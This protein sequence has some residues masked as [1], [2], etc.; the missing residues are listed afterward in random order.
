MGGDTCILETNGR[1]K[2]TKRARKTRKK[3]SVVDGKLTDEKNL[4]DE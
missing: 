1:E 4:M 2:E 3:A